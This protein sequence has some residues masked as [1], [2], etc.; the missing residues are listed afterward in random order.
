ML[1]MLKCKTLL[2]IL[3]FVRLAI[4]LI[5]VKRDSEYYVTVYCS[6]GSS[7]YGKEKGACYQEPA[8]ITSIYKVCHRSF[9]PC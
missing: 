3:F 4:L 6:E 7:V 9:I 1:A 5:I 8:Y 2:H